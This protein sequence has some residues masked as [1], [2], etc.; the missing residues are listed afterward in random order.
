MLSGQRLFDGG[1]V[2]DV[3]ADVLKSEPDWRA[4]PAD[5][6]HALRLLLRRCLQKDRRQR[7]RDIADARFLL[8]DASTAPSLD[9]HAAP[10]R[11]PRR[12]RLTWQLIPAIATLAAMAIAWSLPRWPH[13]EIRLE[14]TTPSNTT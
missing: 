4:L 2:T 10:A 1:T 14:V 8:E 5:T 3:L 6:P 11:L 13:P 7:L 9:L 12:E